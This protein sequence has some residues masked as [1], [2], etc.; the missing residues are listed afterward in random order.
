MT[1]FMV[2]TIVSFCGIIALL[3]CF[4][5]FSREV[6]RGRDKGRS[7]RVERISC[8]VSGAGRKRGR[9]VEAE[10]ITHRQAE[11]GQAKFEK[12]RSG[13]RKSDAANVIALAILLGSRCNRGIALQKLNDFIA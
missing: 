7:V 3:W 9:T 12:A 13:A 10:R 2:F 6:S 11:F 8:A 5:G 1:F 4:K